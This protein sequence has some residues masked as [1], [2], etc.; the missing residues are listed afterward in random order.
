VFTSADGLR[1]SG[2]FHDG[3]EG[4]GFT[5]DTSAYTGWIV[6]WT[7]DVYGW[8]VGFL[9]VGFTFAGLLTAGV[10]FG[11]RWLV[12]LPG[13]R[14][15]LNPRQ[16]RRIAILAALG[17]SFGFMLVAAVLYFL[18]LPVSESLFELFAIAL[19]ALGL[20]AFLDPLFERLQRALGI[21]AGHPPTARQSTGAMMRRVSFAILLLNG[22]LHTL[23]H[24][25]VKTYPGLSTALVA[26]YGPISTLITTYCWLL[27]WHPDPSRS[28][29]ALRGAVSGM[30][31]G[32]I[33]MWGWVPYLEGIGKLV[34]PLFG[35]LVMTLVPL[36]GGLAMD[37][38][39][40]WGLG[41]ESRASLS[42]TLAMLVA[43]SVA[44]SLYWLW[45]LG[46][47]KNL[48]HAFA[49]KLL[50]IP[51]PSLIMP[52]ERPELHR[53]FLLLSGPV[54]VAGWGLG[55]F[56]SGRFDTLLMEQR[57]QTRS[58]ELPGFS[59]N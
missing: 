14:A 40:G 38:R 50:P 18:S 6:T 15:C 41:W 22:V 32:L 57:L 44:G 11:I 52:S 47:E 27:G 56:L 9:L 58:P 13:D 35:V 4:P 7:P 24:E 21:A 39:W 19:V 54:G 46:F 20:V 16:R 29:A 53:A 23:L 25:F 37:R 45:V 28:R 36:A 43:W 42:M 48:W 17:S 10:F 5:F 30:V 3:E 33:V 8:N 34:V 59:R 31:A 12:F 49:T 51:A 26:G 55:L 2:W 1:Y